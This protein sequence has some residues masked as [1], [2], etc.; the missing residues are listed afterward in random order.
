MLQT[1][2]LGLIAGTIYGLLAVG[3]VLIYKGSGVLNF[4]QGEIGTASLY[5]TSVV[6]TRLHAPYLAAAAAAV[7]TALLIGLL[8]E[9][10]VVRPMGDSSRIAVTIATVGLLTLL[11]SLE[12][13]LFGPAPQPVPK[14]LP[15]IGRSLA[16]VFVQPSQQ[17]SV[18]VIVAV[19]ATLTVFLRFTDFGL[20]VLAAA[21]DAT[22]VR[23]M[24]IP[25][26]R[27]SAFT[28]AVGSG[29]AAV[30]ALLISPTIGIGVAPGFLGGF[31]VSALAAALVGGL[32]SLPGAFVGGLVIG[33]VEA[34]AFN[35]G[36]N[37][38]GLPGFREMG[39]F[40]VILL[41]LLFRPRG[42]LGR[43]A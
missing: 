25:L 41:V 26:S 1:I 10:F 19:G 30:A 23:L 32:N 31:F 17:L 34:E 16:G 5:V 12:F 2:V 18:L 8:F 6:S 11:V 40:A 22:A 7:A 3:I 36:S 27:V 20:A 38:Q 15:G 24:G 39:V 4:A 21:Q 35:L 9:R 37:V 29:V 14:P 33:I 13:L 28:W 42:L 43:A